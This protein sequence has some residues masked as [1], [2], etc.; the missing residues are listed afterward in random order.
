MKL[1]DPYILLAMDGMDSTDEGPAS[2][3]TAQRDEPTALFFALFG[4]IYEALSASSA[5]ATPSAK[6]RRNALI[7]LNALKSLVKPA[8]SGRALFDPPIFSEFM[9]LC[10]RMAMTESAAAQ[11][12]L[13]EVISVFATSQAGNINALLKA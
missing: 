1:G 12:L 11:V 9:S 13:V 8:F 2:S 6:L 7:A 5:D 4:L 10:Y 3:A